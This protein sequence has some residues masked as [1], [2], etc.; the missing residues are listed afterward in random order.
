MTSQCL[1]AFTR[2]SLFACVSPVYLFSVYTYVY[3]ISVYTCT[4]LCHKCRNRRVQSSRRGNLL[5]RRDD[6]IHVHVDATFRCSVIHVLVCVGVYT[7]LCRRVSF[8]FSSCI[9]LLFSFSYVSL[10]S[11]SSS[12]AIK[13]RWKINRQDSTR[14]IEI[15]R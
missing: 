5:K 14:L 4:K 15:D 3:C 13:T 1:P 9:S 7:Y 12:I 10:A 6:P 8:Y 2:V 11:S